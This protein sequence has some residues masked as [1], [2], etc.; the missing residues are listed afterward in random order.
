MLN[1][2]IKKSNYILM[3][4]L[5]LMLPI[6]FL[7]NFYLKVI[8]DI[9]FSLHFY[10]VLH[11][12]IPLE[13]FIYIYNITKKNIKIT[14]YDILGFILILMGIVVTINAVDVQTSIW[15]AY[16]RN[17]GLL[18]LI[19]Y[20]LLFLNSKSL[21]S[22]EIKNIINWFF[23]IGI[24]QFIYC[25]LQVFVRGKYIEGFKGGIAYMASGFIGNPNMLGSFCI[26][27]LGLSLMMYFI[28]NE[29][30]YFIFSI[31]F[32][33]NLVLAQSTGPFFS[34]I[35][36]FIFMII[37]LKLKKMI[38]IKKVLLVLVT[39]IGT[40]LLVSYG[41]EYYSK[42]VFNDKIDSSY[43]IKGDI[44]NTLLL[45]SNKKSEEE[46]AVVQNYGSGRLIIWKNTIKIV[47]KYFWLGAGIDNLGYV[48]PQNGY[49]YLDKAHNEYLQLLATE[50]IFVLLAYLILLLSLFI[51]SI[52]SKKPLAWIL[53]VGFIG[54]ALQAFMNIS[55]PR[56]APFYFIVL[57]SLA[58]LVSKSNEDE[59]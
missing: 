17:E 37:F 21:D 14:K 57:G 47:P 29:R 30:K 7:L 33:I 15:G 44:A 39:F 43:T 38:N 35:V 23:I 31:I 42:V 49:G 12:L 19:G 1:K 5:V 8:F 50:G 25:C 46:E 55:V 13:I 18:A 59:C 48:Y 4:L 3:I 58:G 28:Y 24:I 51:D 53:M 22:K 6:T 41:S 36:L 26:L 45:F 40:F 27:V 11:L 10:E 9:N 20:Y 16:L 54:Y 56:V 34:F 2:I 32:F 52:K